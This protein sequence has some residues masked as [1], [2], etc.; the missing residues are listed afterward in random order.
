M[1]VEKELLSGMDELR[2]AGRED[3]NASGYNDGRL[4][5]LAV[6]LPRN[7]WQREYIALEGSDIDC[8]ITG[9]RRI[10]RCQKEENEDEKTNDH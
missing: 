2:S 3:G 4:E 1:A 7:G 5:W 9:I 10:E 6:P 8:E